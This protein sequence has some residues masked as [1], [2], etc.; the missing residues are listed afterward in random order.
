MLNFNFCPKCGSKHFEQNNANSQKCS[1]C[2]F[3]YFFNAAAA[4]V[5]I[6]K[7]DNDEILVAVRAKEPAKG[8]Y[9]LPGGFVNLLE[10]SE[11]AIKREISEE[12]NLEVENV[13]YLFSIPNTYVYS[14]F[15]YK[16]LDMVYECTISKFDSLRADDDVAEL[17][18]IKIKDLNSD[19]FGLNS[20]KEVVRKI[21]S[22]KYN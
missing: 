7:T 2:G 19:D 5:G 4:V 3:V 22:E 13:E 6:I 9:D 16:T 1:D 14:T 17:K 10:T 11:N 15:E 8:S 20:I 12:T 21:K 18:F